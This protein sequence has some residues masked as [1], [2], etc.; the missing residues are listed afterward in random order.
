MLLFLNRP[1]INSKDAFG[2]SSVSGID[3]QYSKTLL[4]K[5]SENST[6][7][8]NLLKFELGN[9]I[10]YLMNRRTTICSAPLFEVTIG[11]LNTEEL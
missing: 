6:H 3:L 4:I 8:I 2:G 7:V 10:Y 5:L 1:C 9:D 11:N